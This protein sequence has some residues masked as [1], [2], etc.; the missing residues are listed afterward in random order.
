MKK[1]Q[2]KAIFHLTVV[3]LI[4]VGLIICAVQ[5]FRGGSGREK[6]RKTDK[7]AWNDSYHDHREPTRDWPGLFND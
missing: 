2:L 4:F 3:A 7:N 6:R 1:E 5:V